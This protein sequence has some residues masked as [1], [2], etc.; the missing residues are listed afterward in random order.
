MTPVRS[1]SQAPLFGRLH[2]E[3]V[4]VLG[5]VDTG[6]S[7]SCLGWELYQQHAPT[8][9]PLE[10]FPTIVRGAN[11]GPLPIA[12]R[13]R[14]LQLQWGPARAWARFVIIRG[15]EDPSA[16]IGMDI[17]A[18]LQVQIDTH[19]RLAAPRIPLHTDPTPV[20]A[21]ALENATIPPEAVR[22]VKITNP[23][24]SDEVLYQPEGLPFSINGHTA[25]SKGQTTWVAVQNSRTEPYKIQAGHQLGTLEVVTTIQ[26]TPLSLAS[27]LPEIPPHL[28]QPQR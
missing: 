2:L 27:H 19:T 25:V 7:V 14:Y 12:G 22:F 1:P 5:L 15:L 4:P 11:G 17:M 13:T 6:A 3:Q 23:W 26:P 10:E 16:L 24:P 21:T 9:G 18:P 28:T 8:W 20:I